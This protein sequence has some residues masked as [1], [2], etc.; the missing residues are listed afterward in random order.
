MTHTIQIRIEKSLKQKA[1]LLF[2]EMGLDLPTA[3]RIFLT[4]VVSTR[5]IPFELSAPLTENGFTEEFEDIVSK[6]IKEDKR[7]GPFD[8]ADALIADLDKQK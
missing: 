8:S 2:S 1:D 7:F 4:K 3:I 6:A 5:K